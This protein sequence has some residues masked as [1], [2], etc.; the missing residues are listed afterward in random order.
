MWFSLW[1]CG[2]D[3]FWQKW[4]KVVMRRLYI[5]YCTHKQVAYSG[6]VAL[7]STVPYSTCNVCITCTVYP[8]RFWEFSTCTVLHGGVYCTVLYVLHV[9]GQNI[10]AL[11]H[12]VPNKAS[13]LCRLDLVHKWQN[14]L[15]WKHGDRWAEHVV[16]QERATKIIPGYGII[17]LIWRKT[18]CFGI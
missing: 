3:S 15:V 10:N 5:S 17:S 1:H 11:C 12:R 16:L 18:L 8:R 13:L 9:C 14:F 4:C 7:L 6:T 2:Y